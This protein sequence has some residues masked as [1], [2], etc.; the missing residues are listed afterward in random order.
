MRYGIVS[1]VHA[2]LPALEAVFDALASARV[3]KVLCAGDLVGYGPNP[4]ECIEFLVERGVGCIAGNHDL[5]ALERLPDDRAIRLA[6]ETLQWTRTVLTRQSR[7]FLEKLPI[8]A[9]VDG[10][11]VLAHG[12]LEDPQEY[13]S[14]ARRATVELERMSRAYPAAKWLILGHTHRAQAFQLRAGPQQIGHGAIRLPPESRWLLNPGS[15][16]QSRSWSVR[17]RYLVVD[18]VAA[19]ARFA[20]VKYD[21]ARCRRD[22]HRVGLPRY[23]YHLSPWRTHPALGALRR[24][25][26]RL[27][28]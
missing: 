25:G 19:T 1:D 27:V 16:G 5:I 9:E 23:G 12:S 10:R 26:R 22:L 6:R 2:N 13:V 21:V 4:N 3:D 15:V 20:A 11:F 28:G 14:S 24:L 18:T 8:R 17:A 7:D